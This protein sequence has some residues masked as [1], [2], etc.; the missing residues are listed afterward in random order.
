MAF[1]KSLLT[2]LGA[3]IAIASLFRPWFS[4]HLTFI[5]KV[6]SGIAFPGA[7][8]V[9]LMGSLAVLVV[10]IYGIIN[11]KNVLIKYV[12]FGFSLLTLLLTVFFLY[13]YSQQSSAPG[14]SIQMR[15]GLP[16]TFAGIILMIAGALPWGIKGNSGS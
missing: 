11:S 2:P 9:V 8:W 6:V 1:L 3:I 14:V 7:F 4:G 10:Y 15:H 13:R 12:G 16:L 5:G